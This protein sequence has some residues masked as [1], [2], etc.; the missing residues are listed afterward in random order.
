M[1]SVRKSVKGHGV[2]GFKTL[3]QPG[4]FGYYTP[5]GYITRPSNPS[6][7]RYSVQNHVPIPI[8][9]FN[10]MTHR[11]SVISPTP[12]AGSGYTEEFL[13]VEA[14]TRLAGQP[15]QMMQWRTSSSYFD[16]RRGEGLH[17]NDP[18]VTQLFPPSGSNEMPENL[19]PAATGGNTPAQAPIVTPRT[20]MPNTQGGVNLWPSTAA[21]STPSTN[22]ARAEH[23]AFSTPQLRNTSNAH[24]GTHPRFDSAHVPANIGNEIANKV[25]QS[26]IS[27]MRAPEPLGPSAPIPIPVGGGPATPRPTTV[28]WW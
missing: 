2:S 8:N 3:G 11:P 7:S 4:D 21:I 9:N 22:N 25:V 13:P 24:A 15:E 14:G 12:N 20:A 19:T 23:D 6:S 5:S 1:K 27:S 18:V 17:S 16:R 10:A 26:L 28:T